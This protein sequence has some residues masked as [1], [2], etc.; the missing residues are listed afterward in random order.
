M[1]ALSESSISCSTFSMVVPSSASSASR[2]DTNSR[3]LASRKSATLLS[4]MTTCSRGHMHQPRM[5]CTLHDVFMVLMADSNAHMQEGGHYKGL[6]SEVSPT[7]LGSRTQP[8]SMQRQPPITVKQRATKST[9]RWRKS[10][11]PATQGWIMGLAQYSDSGKPG[12]SNP[13]HG[14][15]PQSRRQGRALPAGSRAM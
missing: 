12:L 14:F 3:E 13:F 10:F 8:L 1:G 11:I 6:A 15:Q 2:M 4:S 5:A 9:R 7:P